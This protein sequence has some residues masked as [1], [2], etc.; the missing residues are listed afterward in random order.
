[1]LARVKQVVDQYNGLENT[2]VTAFDRYYNQLT[3]P[4][5]GG[6]IAKA[7]EDIANLPSWNSLN[8]QID[9][10]VWRLVTELT[11]GDPLSW[12]LTKS[13]GA[14]QARAR[15]LLDLGANTATTEIRSVIKLVKDSFGISPLFAELDTLDTIPKLKAQAD[16]RPARSSSG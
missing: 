10:T 1:M 13:V 11:D 14:L 3:S 2:V 12:M 5:L 8:G 4:A 6:R 7:I 15:Q 16:T 9:P